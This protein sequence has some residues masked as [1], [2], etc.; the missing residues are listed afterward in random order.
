MPNASSPSRDSEGRHA[1]RST[2]H[3][4]HRLVAVGKYQFG[5][6]RQEGALEG[7]VVQAR[8]DHVGVARGEGVVRLAGRCQIHHGPRA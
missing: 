6:G 8:A 3:V 5:E 1:A 4:R 2:A 7:Q